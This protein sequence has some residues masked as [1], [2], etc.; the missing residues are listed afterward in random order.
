MYSKGCLPIILQSIATGAYKIQN[1]LDQLDVIEVGEAELKSADPAGASFMDID[2][3]AD[4]S[5][6][7]LRG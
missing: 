6:L 1:V 7:L 2:T 5:R 4:Y 3:P